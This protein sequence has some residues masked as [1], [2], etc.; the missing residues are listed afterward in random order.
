MISRNRKVCN[1]RKK[2]EK[3]E[4]ATK[5]RPQTIS[6]NNSWENLSLGNSSSHESDLSCFKEVKVNRQMKMLKTKK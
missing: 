2:K 6:F 3:K 1:A 4:A 5:R